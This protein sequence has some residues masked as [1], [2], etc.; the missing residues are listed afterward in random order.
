[1][2]Y[3]IE[4]VSTCNSVIMSKRRIHLPFSYGGIGWRWCEAVI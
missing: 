1:L 2:S 3:N 4:F